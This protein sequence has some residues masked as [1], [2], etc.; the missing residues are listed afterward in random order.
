MLSTTPAA[1]TETVG[2]GVAMPNPLPSASTPACPHFLS[3]TGDLRL[4]IY[5]TLAPP[6]FFLPLHALPP[7]PVG[8][9][10]FWGH[11]RRVR[12]SWYP[13]CRFHAGVRGR[14]R[15]LD[16]WEK[17]S[18]RI[19]VTVRSSFGNLFLGAVVP[20]KTVAACRK[21]DGGTP[22]GRSRRILDKTQARRRRSTSSHICS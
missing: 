8:R 14:L 3:I 9:P 11:R 21:S 5:F 17:P 12:A 20:R 16:G 22:L 19:S 18:S 13:T 4:V 2:N 1:A 7:A 15:A 10:F 6:L